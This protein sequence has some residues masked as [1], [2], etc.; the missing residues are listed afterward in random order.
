MIELQKTMF[1]LLKL[2][3]PNWLREEIRGLMSNIE[4]F[5]VV[6]ACTQ[7]TDKNLERKLKK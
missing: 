2:N 3:Q 4:S 6:K 7:D 1:S 5:V